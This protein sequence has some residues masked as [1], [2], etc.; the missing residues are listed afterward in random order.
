MSF[1]ETRPRR[2]NLSFGLADPARTILFL[3]N[4]VA[5]FHLSNGLSNIQHC[6]VLYDTYDMIV[7]LCMKLHFTRKATKSSITSLPLLLATTEEGNFSGLPDVDS[8]SPYLLG[9][10]VVTRAS[11]LQYMGRVNGRVSICRN[12]GYFSMFPVKQ[13]FAPF[14]R[15]SKNAVFIKSSN[16]LLFPYPL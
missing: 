15:S 14:W 10:S 1:I 4:R 6:C 5:T 3:R 9:H 7:E 8:R 2:I 13:G 11:L 12:R 16:L